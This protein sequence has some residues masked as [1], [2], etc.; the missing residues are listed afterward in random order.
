MPAADVL[1]VARSGRQL[2]QAARA[3]GY[4]PVVVD[5]FGDVDTEAACV[6]NVKLPATDAF[7]FNARALLQA[8]SRLRSADG[9]MP[10]VWGSG[11]EAQPHLLAA[12]ARSWPLA[13]CPVAALFAANDP[14]AF[15]QVQSAIDFDL[16][17]LAYGRVPATGTWLVKQRGSCG[18]DGVGRARRGCLTGQRQYL[19]REVTGAPLSA[20]FLAGPGAVELLGVCEPFALQSHPRFPYRFSAAVAAPDVYAALRGRLVKLVETL[21]EAFGLRGLCGIDF[22]R[23]GANGLALIEMNVRP[24]ATFDLLA[25][26]GEVFSAHLNAVARRCSVP[27]DVRAMAI[28]YAEAPLAVPRALRWPDWAADRP[29]P[30][31]YLDAGMPLCSVSA[32]ASTSSEA[33]ELLAD[34]FAE[35]RRLLHA[36]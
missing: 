32:S 4:R 16:P 13:G 22:I 19:Q 14:T 17:A 2:A 8:L 15:L 12:I 5:L 33:R 35:L 21:T 1:I 23:D 30:T 28:Y 20:A 7:G 34:R 24:P 27:A 18:G 29:P 25:A 3:A 10:L 31:T 6:S 26:P 11:W 36:G 9:E